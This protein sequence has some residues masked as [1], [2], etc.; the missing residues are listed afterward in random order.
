MP[1]IK[2]FHKVQ[3]IVTQTDKERLEA[4]AIMYWRYSGIE[5]KILK[6]ETGEIIIQTKQHKHFIDRYL[7]QKELIERTKELFRKHL[8]IEF[9]LH[10][11][12]TAYSPTVSSYTPV[13]LRFFFHLTTTA[14]KSPKK[15]A[16]AYFYLIVNRQ[17]YSLC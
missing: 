9:S 14:A 17:L 11:H 4:C 10:V 12:A 5:F 2:D 16:V 3:E 1:I 15:I 8:P 6:C 7:N 13:Y